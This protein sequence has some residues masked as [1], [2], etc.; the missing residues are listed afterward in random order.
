MQ[1]AHGVEGRCPY[2]DYHVIEFMA[3]LPESFRV[4][5]LRDKFALR[6]AFADRL[7]ASLIDR[8]KFAYRAP[9]MEAFVADD[10]GYV[11]ELLGVEAVREAELF[12]AEA[13][14]GLLRRMKTR[15]P[16]QFTTRDNMAFVQVLS[17]QLL[18]RA[19]IRDF[20]KRKRSIGADIQEVRFDAS[21]VTLRGISRG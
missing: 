18:Y 16:D 2:L 10:A 3:T 12:D 14:E 17:T 13:C 11:G 4:N 9:E 8:P 21:G 5:G 19:F 15:R 1:S 20:D 6:R 7:P